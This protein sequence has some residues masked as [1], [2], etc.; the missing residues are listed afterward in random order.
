MPPLVQRVLR[1]AHARLGGAACGAKHVVLLSS[2][3]P[4]GWCLTVMLNRRGELVGHGGEEEPHRLLLPN[5]MCLLRQALMAGVPLH[6]ACWDAE[7]MEQAGSGGAVL[8][9]AHVW[10]LE[11]LAWRQRRQR[12]G[13]EEGGGGRWERRGGAGQRGQRR[14]EPGVW[15]LRWGPWGARRSGRC[16]TRRRRGY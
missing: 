6:L 5:V 8:L 13:G 11:D 15:C 12:R 16:R 10:R 1:D 2:D 14:R 7:A 3:Q 4:R 9:Q